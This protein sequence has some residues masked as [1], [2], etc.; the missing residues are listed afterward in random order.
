MIRLSPTPGILLRTHVCM[1]GLT[2]GAVNPLRE[3]S[4]LYRETLPKSDCDFGMGCFQKNSKV[5]RC[6]GIVSKRANAIKS[7][8]DCG[9]LLVSLGGI[10]MFH[11]ACGPTNRPA[12]EH[13]FLFR[14]PAVPTVK[15][16]PPPFFS[17]HD[18]IR[19]QW[20]AFNVPADREKLLVVLDWKGFE[21]PLI[22][23]P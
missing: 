9:K 20:V 22:E 16:A 13:G 11:P 5:L 17:A 12:R 7:T 6:Q 14:C 3:P 4:L 15:T 18:E 8:L 2:R 1:S 19:P 21:T 23:V 10:H